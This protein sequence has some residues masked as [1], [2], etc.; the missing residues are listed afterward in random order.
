V[1][2]NADFEQMVNEMARAAR[3]QEQLNSMRVSI[4]AHQRRMVC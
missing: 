1:E 2:A 3:E 4:V